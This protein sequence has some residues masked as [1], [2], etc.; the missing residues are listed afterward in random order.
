MPERSLWS[1]LRR[2]HLGGYKFRRQ[3]P[4]GPYVLDF[5]CAAL[6]LCVEVDGRGHDAFGRAMQDLDR[7]ALL[8]QMGIVVIRIRNEEVTD[9]PDSTWDRI[10]GAVVRIIRERT[11]KSELTV[12]RELFGLSQRGVD[13]RK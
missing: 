11:G 12:L 7:S 2:H 8:S 1:W 10:V 3:H 9:D 13:R 4:L 5:Y 6:K